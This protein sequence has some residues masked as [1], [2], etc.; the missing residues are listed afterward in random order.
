MRRLQRDLENLFDRSVGHR[1]AA[2]EEYPPVNLT[3]T[4][5]GLVIEALCAG[6]D[7][8]TLDLT[9]V[10]DALTLRGERRAEAIPDNRYHRR[11]RHVGPFTRTIRVGDR[12][13]PDRVEAVYRDGLLRVTLS[14][15]P[16]AGAR[17]IT[18]SG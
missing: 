8:A 13:D 2:G 15:A 12:F 18:I 17:K 3:R 16:Q 9:L 4:Q 10:G 14:R 6:V 5:D 1:G 7:R 11:E